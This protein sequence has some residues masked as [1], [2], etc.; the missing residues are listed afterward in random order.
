MASKKKPTI[1]SLIHTIGKLKLE[2]QRYIFKLNKK[3]EKLEEELKTE[4]QNNIENQKTIATLQNEVEE[5][6][7]KLIE[8]KSKSQQQPNDAINKSNAKTKN[9]FEVE[10]IIADK[11]IKRKKHYLVR[12]KGYDENHD[13]W[14]PK[15]NLNCPDILDKYEKCKRNRKQ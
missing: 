8:F 14:Q 1:E 7:L 2:H 11:M 5:L 6:R 10:A 15:Q 3:N 4:R 12:W 9:E 13:S